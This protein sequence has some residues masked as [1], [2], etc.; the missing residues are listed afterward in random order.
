MNLKR[1]YLLLPAIFLFSFIHAQENIA[2][3]E[4]VTTICYKSD[5]GNGTASG[6]SPA[7]A[8]D[9]DE[10]TYWESDNSFSQIFCLDL[11]KEYDISK[12]VLK[13]NAGFYPT[14]IT[15]S[16]SDNVITKAGDEKNKIFDLNDYNQKGDGPV[17][18]I[19]EVENNEGS[20][21]INGFTTRYV[22]FRTRGRNTPNAGYQ[23]NEFEIYG[24]ENTDEKE[25]PILPEDQQ[26]A[27]DDL[28]SKFITKNLS[29]YG[30]D[31]S[32]TN[33][34][35]SMNAD[36]SWSDIDYNDKKSIGGW[37]PQKHLSRLKTMALA[38][39]SPKSDWFENADMQAKIEKGLLYYK[40]KNPIA[41]DNWWYTDIGDPQVYMIPA[42]MLKGYSSA[43][44]LLD[45]SAYLQDR[46]TNEAHQGQNLAWVAQITAYKGCTENDYDLTK[47]AFEKMASILKI[48][49]TQ[50]D[51]GIKADGSFHQH[52]SQIYSG[53]YGLTV[54][55]FISYFMEL[56]SGTL[57]YEV[58]TEERITIFRNM[59]L[60]GHQLLGYRSAIDFGTVGRGLARS[61]S[62]SNISATVL[63]RMITADP[64]KKNEYEAWRL[65]LSGKAFPAV[66]NKHFWNSDMMTHHGE[67]YYLSAKIISKRTYGTE[68][69]N[70]EN[71]LGYNLPLGTTHIMTH[72]K[73]YKDIFPSWDWNKLPGTTSAQDADAAKMPDGYLI[74]SNN[75]GGGV[76]NGKS[77]IIAYQHNYKNVQAYKAYFMFGDAMLCLGTNINLSKEAEIATSVNQSFLNG[78]VT[79][80]H[81]SVTETMAA[82]TLNTYSDL[83]W[84]YHDNVGYVFPVAANITVKNQIQSGTWGSIN[85]STSTAQ[86]RANVFSAWISHGTKPENGEYQYIVKPDISLEDFGNYAES[87]GFVVVQNNTE[88]QIVRNDMIKT[89]GI[90]FHT[91]AT[92]DMGNGINITSNKAILVLIEQDGANY[93]ISVADPNCK[94][95]SVALTINKQLE[96]ASA[97][98]TDNSTT[99]T[100][101]LPTKEY[102]GSSVTNDY[103]DLNHSFIVENEIDSNV[104]I[105][106]N[107][108]KTKTTISFEKG[109][110]NRLDMYA[111]DGQFIETKLIDP[112]IEHVDILLDNYPPG[113]YIAYLSGK[114]K[115]TCQKLIVIK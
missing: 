84:I 57:F 29:D 17:T 70:G 19:F 8:I 114:G 94:E 99:I 112:G 89:A 16:Y 100:I 106:P 43:K 98:V 77:G 81:G 69:L 59:L 14:A 22:A 88:A 58:F 13:W 24:V 72:G 76:S 15:L 10:S 97:V 50:G 35:N 21:K 55:D 85:G 9:G 46:T 18:D 39:R 96:G 78:D 75:F 101:A 3:N 47:R 103:I 54:T 7:N 91:P 26:K 6:S 102:S 74:G 90:V 56:A 67:N 62:C 12:I 23:L 80:S 44:T 36:G 30:G 32:P 49:K 61:G 83:K 4:S 31:A 92:V 66:G 113:T 38:F 60:N 104:S 37:D 42:L 68:C 71:L 115:S 82:K 86:Q 51:E 111:F 20:H 48:V 34:Y 53:G 33:Y 2:L 1:T 73:E 79:V 25:L 28:I 87:H 27:V 41:S 5:G 64:D 40:S 109:E 107:P 52:H 105:Y 45:I 95:A 11:G 65:H 108:A 63:N 93:K 110:F